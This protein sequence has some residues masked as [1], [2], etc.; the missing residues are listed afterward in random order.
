[1][2]KNTVTNM[3]KCPL[4]YKKASGIVMCV[5]GLELDGETPR[6]CSHPEL[7]CPFTRKGIIPL[8]VLAETTSFPLPAVVP[9]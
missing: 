4:Y 1:M 6:P 7:P 8:P 9:G 3:A 5:N 2:V